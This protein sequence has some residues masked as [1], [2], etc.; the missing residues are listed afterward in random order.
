[1][2]PGAKA[3]EKTDKKKQSRRKVEQTAKRELLTLR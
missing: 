2:G 3:Q 1:M